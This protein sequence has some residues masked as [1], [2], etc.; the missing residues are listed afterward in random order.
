VITGGQDREA[1]QTSGR[2]EDEIASDD[3]KELGSNAMTDE[4]EEEW[5]FA[6]TNHMHS[7][8]R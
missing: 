8:K 2:C 3:A 4:Q 5:Q 7:L 6:R 1:A